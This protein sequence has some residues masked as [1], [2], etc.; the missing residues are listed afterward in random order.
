MSEKMRSLDFRHEAEVALGDSG[1]DFTKDQVEDVSAQ[2]ADA[3][4]RGVESCQSAISRLSERVAE[5]ETTLRN[6]LT[7]FEYLLTKLEPRSTNGRY[8]EKGNAWSAADVAAWDVRQRIDAARS[9]LAATP[10]PP[11]KSEPPQ[12][13]FRPFSE[14]RDALRDVSDECAKSE[15]ESEL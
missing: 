7:W 4:N 3:C 5:L 14:L 10:A 9:A 15:P 13:K 11:T 2:L 6:N 1:D 8:G 12:G